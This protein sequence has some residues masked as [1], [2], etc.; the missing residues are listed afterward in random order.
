MLCSHFGY[1]VAKKKKE[2][3]ITKR[4]SPKKFLKPWICFLSV[5]LQ[6]R[7]RDWILF[8]LPIAS[9]NLS[10]FVNSGNLHFSENSGWENKPSVSKNFSGGYPF[11]NCWMSLQPQP[12]NENK[13][14]QKLYF[15]L[16]YCKLPEL[17]GCFT[18]GGVEETTFE[19]KDSK[20][21]PRQRP[22]TYFSRTDP[23]EAKVRNGRGRGPGS[24]FF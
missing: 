1:A 22:R 16:N 7:K 3:T 8:L 23:L 21:N 5:N 14:F 18:R 17:A 6:V 11:C 13:R 20:K 2:R 24:Q 4:Y 9:H 15:N 10:H 12:K 19:A